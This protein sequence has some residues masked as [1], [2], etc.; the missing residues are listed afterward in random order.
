[1]YMYTCI[2]LVPDALAPVRREG[3]RPLLV[4]WRPGAFMIM[5]MLIYNIVVFVD[6]SCQADAT[7]SSSIVAGLVYLC[8]MEAG[9]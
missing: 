9:C 3:G 1:M 6:S 7:T 8:G 2:C 4:V 5:I